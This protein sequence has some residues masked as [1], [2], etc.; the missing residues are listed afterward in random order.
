VPEVTEKITVDPYDAD[1]IDLNVPIE[2]SMAKFNAMFPDEP[3]PA[4]AVAAEPAPAPAVAAEPEPAPAA[5]APAEPAPAPAVEAPKP[6]P[7]AALQAEREALLAQITALSG[8]QSATQ[9]QISAMAEQLKQATV[10]EEPKAPPAPS[11]PPPEQVYAYLNDKIG[12]IENKLTEASQSDPAA[13]PAIMRELFAAQRQLLMYDTRQQLSTLQVPDP[14]AIT[15]RA[16]TATQQRMEFD[17]QRAAI[18]QEFPQLALGAQRDEEFHAAV[19]EIYGP[20]YKSGTDPTDALTKAVTL[21]AAARGVRSASQLAAEQAQAKAAEAAEAERKAAEAKLAEVEAELKK[22]KAA[23]P[24]DRKADAVQR[25]LAAAAATP[26]NLGEVVTG[27]SND[28]KGI[29][30]KYDFESMS[31]EEFMR[32]PQSDVDKFED[33]LRRHAL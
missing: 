31:I 16:V 33:V 25:N 28:G 9:A 11:E 18:M 12:A 6:D 4:P 23:T 26:P 3:E 29:A 13:T 21:V 24:A 5:A 8:A 17:A 32:I 1:V 2:E 19:M 14:E 10:K 30:D 20:L 27:V 15:E 22:S 7:L